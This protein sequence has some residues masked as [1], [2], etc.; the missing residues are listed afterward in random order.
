VQELRRSYARA[1]DLPGK[2][3][4]FRN[5]IKYFPSWYTKTDSDGNPWTSNV[6]PRAAIANV[7]SRTDPQLPLFDFSAVGDPPFLVYRFS[8]GG[9]EY[10]FCSRDHVTL[11]GDTHDADGEPLSGCGVWV[12]EA[13]DRVVMALRLA[14]YSGQYADTVSRERSYVEALKPDAWLPKLLDIAKRVKEDESQKHEQW[15]KK[16]ERQQ[17]DKN[18]V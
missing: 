8:V 15:R 3:W 13:P 12:I 5:A 17:A 1:I 18:F 16:W 7:M 10:A 6:I 14:Y 11:Y 9:K 2:L 4:E